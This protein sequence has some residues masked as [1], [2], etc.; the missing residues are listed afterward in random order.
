[1]NNAPISGKID[2]KSAGNNKANVKGNLLTERACRVDWF[3]QAA[4][5]TTNNYV[6]T[7]GGSS[8]AG[9]VVGGGQIGFKGTT[10]TGDNE[11]SFLSTALIFDITQKPAIQTKVE[12]T[13][14][15]HSFFFFGFSDAT[16]ETTPDAT[17]DA[18]GGT[19]AAAATDAVG[20]FMDGDKSSLLY[21]G[22][23]AT[24]GSVTATSTGITWADGEK[25]T[26]RVD[27]DASGNAKFFVDGVQKG[28]TAAAVTDV[29]LCATFNYGTREGAANY[30]YARYLAKFQDVP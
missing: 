26:L 27:L 20:F 23:I 15:A 7:L 4:I 3:D 8:D 12:V 9:A 2:F 10:G 17:I 19:I 28:Y 1:M 14:A 25:R 5:D 21:Y 22:S 13:D 6:Q 16:S 29:P 18:S 24:G 11:I 30:L